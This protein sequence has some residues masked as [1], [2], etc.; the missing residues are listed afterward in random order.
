MICY[1]YLT[2]RCKLS[3]I[4]LYKVHQKSG[5]RQLTNNALIE[6]DRKPHD[7]CF[8]VVTLPHVR[9]GQRRSPDYKKCLKRIIISKNESIALWKKLRLKEDTKTLDRGDVCLRSAM[10]AYEQ[11]PQ[12][13]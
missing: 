1:I 12:R 6:T 2:M 10:T 4:G 5:R 13:K 9:N 3:M 7:I 8:K 11:V